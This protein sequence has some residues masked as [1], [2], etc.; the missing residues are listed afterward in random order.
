[1]KDD[2]LTFKSNAKIKNFSVDDIG[3][4]SINDVKELKNIFQ[5]KR[6]TPKKE[7]SNFKLSRDKKD[8][9]DQMGG[10]KSSSDHMKGYQET[11]N[12]FIGGGG[13]SSIPSGMVSGRFNQPVL[14]YDIDLNRFANKSNLDDTKINDIFKSS[15]NPLLDDF[16]RD[17][18]DQFK[19]NNEQ[20]YLGMEKKASPVIDFVNNM[21]D[22]IYKLE[23]KQNQPFY[24]NLNSLIYDGDGNFAGTEGSD[25]FVSNENQNN[26]GYLE[27]GDSDERGQL[28]NE[29]RNLGGNDKN[30]LESLDN[31]LIKNAIEELK[32]KYSPDYNDESYFVDTVND[33][34]EDNQIDEEY[35]KMVEDL[36]EKYKL[37]GGN[38]INI[39]NE[40]DDYPITKAIYKIKKDTYKKSPNYK[41]YMNNNMNLSEAKEYYQ[42]LG[43]E[44]NNI[45]N[46]SGKG[47]INKVI[48]AI[49]KILKDVGINDK[50]LTKDAKTKQINY[51]D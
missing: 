18:Q 28:K 40:T 47:S 1:M 24:N 30:I 22:K 2:K 20:L 42:E 19:L 39:L 31:E 23:R 35:K 12:N 26:D 43:G 3:K 27:Y 5:P 11:K 16:R 50:R 21:S 14:T 8:I 37:L 29:Y 45:I 15:M 6:K 36:K 48:G 34:E 9:L 38:D 17:M 4:L 7:E 10:I 25:N 49:S 46:A 44:D 13:G 33:N 41:K 32:N 51:E